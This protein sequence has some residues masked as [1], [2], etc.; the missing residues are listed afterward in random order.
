MPKGE[1]KKVADKIAGKQ[2]WEVG[3][4]CCKVIV[5]DLNNKIY[6]VFLLVFL[7]Y[8]VFLL[9]FF[10]ILFFVGIEVFI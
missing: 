1:W 6:F 10:Y 3:K 2:N 8:F 9:V 4:N 7:Y 5:F